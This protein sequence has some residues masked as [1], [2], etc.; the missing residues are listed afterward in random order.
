VRKLWRR[1]EKPAGG[2]AAGPQTQ[3][4][5]G[6]IPL[7]RCVAFVRSSKDPSKAPSNRAPAGLL[8]GYLIRQIGRCPDECPMI[9]RGTAR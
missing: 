5:Q 4:N 3:T 9:G 2:A 8:N 6:V 1:G 7:L